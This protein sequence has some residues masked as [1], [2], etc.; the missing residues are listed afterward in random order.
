MSGTHA[1]RCSPAVPVGVPDRWV[2]VPAKRATG[3]MPSEGR[4]VKVGLANAGPAEAALWSTR[5]RVARV[6]LDFFFHCPYVYVLSAGS[7]SP[8]P[9]LTACR[10]TV[11]RGGH[12]LGD[13][14]RAAR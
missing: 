14:G 11:P 7:Q 4:G 5:D 1:N 10:V 9:P 2:W 8:H 3:W 6:L 13:S 12:C